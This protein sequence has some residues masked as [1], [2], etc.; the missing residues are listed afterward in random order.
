MLLL[1]L[2]RFLDPSA[3]AN[4]TTVIVEVCCGRNIKASVQTHQTEEPRESDKKVLGMIRK[5]STKTDVLESDIGVRKIL[6]LRHFIRQ[7][8]QTLAV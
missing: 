4:T 2:V 5:Q 7:C 6:H 3:V 8:C 1:Y